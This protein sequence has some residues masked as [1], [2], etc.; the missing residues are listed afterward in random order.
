MSAPSAPILGSSDH[1]YQRHCGCHASRIGDLRFPPARTSSGIGTYRAD[2]C[3]RDSINRTR[4]RRH[5]QSTPGQRMFPQWLLFMGRD[6]NCLRRQRCERVRASRYRARFPTAY[7]H[8]RSRTKAPRPYADEE[9]PDARST[10]RTSKTAHRDSHDG[11]RK[12]DWKRLGMESPTVSIRRP[13][14]RTF[15]RISSMLGI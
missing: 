14:S 6:A 13:C 4:L 7:R 15:R 1:R 5:A 11:Y 2:A 3:L 9:F 12:S 8:R 10:P